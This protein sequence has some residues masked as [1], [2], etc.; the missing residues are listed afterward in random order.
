LHACIIKTKASEVQSVAAV[1][2]DIN[3]PDTQLQQT[4]F[5][6]GVGHRLTLHLNSL[7]NYR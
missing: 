7:Q 1:S 5:A 4:R 3:E 6:A 2:F